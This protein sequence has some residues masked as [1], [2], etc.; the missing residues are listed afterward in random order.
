MNS[1]PIEQKTIV[2]KCFIIYASRMI[3]LSCFLSNEL[4]EWN[5]ACNSVLLQCP[6]RSN[7]TTPEKY[8]IFKVNRKH[9]QGNWENN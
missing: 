3:Y 8:A 4:H 5:L 1:T 7:V 9:N 2:G 6:I